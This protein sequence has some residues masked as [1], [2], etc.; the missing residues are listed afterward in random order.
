MKVKYFDL[1][2]IKLFHF[3]KI[4]VFLSLKKMVGE[5]NGFKGTPEPSLDPTLFFTKLS[6]ISKFK[7]LIY[8]QIH[9]A[10]FTSSSRQW[11][12]GSSNLHKQN[13]M[14]FFICSINSLS[15]INIK[16]TCTTLVFHAERIQLDFQRPL[17]MKAELAPVPFEEKVLVL[18]EHWNRP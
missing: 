8:C 14:F 17:C 12:E 16:F 4:N 3:H 10:R 6:R 18:C 15:H 1:T 2:E 7:D 11:F 13:E 9:F 5:M